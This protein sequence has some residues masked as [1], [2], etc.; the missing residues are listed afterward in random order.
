MNKLDNPVLQVLADYQAAVWAKD[1]DSFVALYDREAVVFDMWGS[2]SYHGIASWRAMVEGWFG[3][4]GAE[5]VNVNFSA[6]QTIVATD[7]A[8]V[9]AFATYKAVDADGLE[10]RSMDNRLTMTLRLQA[11]GWKI[12]HQHT[13]APIEVGTAQVIFR[14]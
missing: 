13:S 14:R 12:V 8:V 2:W 3:S 1:V 10:L 11:D 9:H 6:A 5:R 4:L 7:L